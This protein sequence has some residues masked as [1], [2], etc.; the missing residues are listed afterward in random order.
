MQEMKMVTRSAAMIGILVLALATGAPARAEVTPASPGLAAHAQTTAD[1]EVERPRSWTRSHW[2]AVKKRWS[3]D[4]MKFDA[5]ADQL[6]QAKAKKRM[7]PRR[8]VRYMEKCMR[9][10]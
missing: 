2:E 7:S 5:C 9:R 4:R 10:K 1:T 6:H 8:Q 3:Q